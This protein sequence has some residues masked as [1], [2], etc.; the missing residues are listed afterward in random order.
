M[1]SLISSSITKNILNYILEKAMRIHRFLF[2]INLN[3]NKNSIAYYSILFSKER[4]GYIYEHTLSADRQGP[5]EHT[6]LV[7]MTTEQDSTILRLEG[8]IR[9]IP[10]RRKCKVGRHIIMYL[11]IQ[12]CW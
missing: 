1:T 4:K 3:Y 8:G 6:N 5:H 7:G 2:A 9:W 12:L 10:W 11:I